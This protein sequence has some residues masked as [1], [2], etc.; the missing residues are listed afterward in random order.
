MNRLK[1]MTVSVA[2]KY[3]LVGF[4]LTSPSRFPGTYANAMAGLLIT[5]FI[6]SFLFSSLEY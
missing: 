4:N 3:F 5:L 2:L 1:I 6:P